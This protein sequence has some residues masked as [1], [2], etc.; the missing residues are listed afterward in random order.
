MTQAYAANVGSSNH[1]LVKRCPPG[2]ISIDPT[3]R[4]AEKLHIVKAENV[5]SEAS[6]TLEK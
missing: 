6:L 1:F 4:Q 3:S 2:P 5:R